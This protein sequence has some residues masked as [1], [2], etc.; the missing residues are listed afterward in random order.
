MMKKE[1]LSLKYKEDINEEDDAFTGEESTV[2]CSTLQCSAVHCRTVKYSTVNYSEVQCSAVQC[3]AV[4]CSTVQAALYRQHCTVK[5]ST[6]HCSTVQCSI[7]QYSHSTLPHLYSTR[8]L[9]SSSLIPSSPVFTHTSFTGLCIPYLVYLHFIFFS[10]NKNT[11]FLVFQV[12]LHT[13][14]NQHFCHI[15]V[16]IKPCLLE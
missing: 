1:S 12:C 9:P 8:S 3:S 10:L 6:V 14:L 5:F 2:N 16:W 13:F 7:V 4:Q 15:I 11:Y